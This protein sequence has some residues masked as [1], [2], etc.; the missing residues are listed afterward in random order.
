MNFRNLVR[1]VRDSP[2]I[3][4]V[5]IRFFR[6]LQQ[7]GWRVP[8]QVFRHVPY[9]GRVTVV[10]PNG[11]SFAIQSMGGAIENGLYWRGIFAHEP[12]SMRRWLKYAS[13]GRCILDIGANSG[14]FA[15]SAAAAGA[16][17]VHAFEPLPR[18][19]RILE[20][21]FHL[22]A[23]KGVSVWPYAVGNESGMA[24]LFDPGIGTDSPTSASLSAQFAHDHFGELPSTIV[25]VITIDEFC[26]RKG[27]GPVDL[28]KLDV[29]GF[30]EQAL[31]GMHAT[32]IRD[33]PVVLMEVLPE[34]EVRLRTVVRDLLGD[35]YQWQAIQE[36]DGTL[37]CNVLLSPVDV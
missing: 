19:H 27:I 21:N 16:Q 15:L 10:L 17:F 9:R 33:R 30:E 22:N 31:R 3:L 20:S 13:Q 7:A 5:L 36:G 26:V 4:G 2:F 14:V 6:A 1:S 12:E 25:E 8:K 23:F 28:I 24:E 34:Y 29:E 11:K 37:N 35:G 18:V 32:L